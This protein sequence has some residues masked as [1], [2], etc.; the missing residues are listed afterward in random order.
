MKLTKRQQWLPYVRQIADSI[1]LKDWPVEIR[2]DP[3]S[4]A[5]A[6]ASVDDSRG[7]KLAWIHLG[8]GFFSESRV[9]QRHTVVHELVHV[10]LME[11]IGAVRRRTDDDAL[12]N[13]IMEYAVDSL[14]NAIAPLLPL[15]PRP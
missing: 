6:I 5:G 11:Y 2:E 3:P 12:L 9:E 14:A 8:D 10:H 7:R 4:T 15:P 1:A 13:E